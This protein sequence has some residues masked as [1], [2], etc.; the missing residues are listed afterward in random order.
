[1]AL[2]PACYAKRPV[3][4]ISGLANMQQRK[5]ED[6]AVILEPLSRPH[7]TAKYIKMPFTLVNTDVAGAGR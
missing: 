5:A 4:G 1:M 2:T 7:L 3:L 6:N